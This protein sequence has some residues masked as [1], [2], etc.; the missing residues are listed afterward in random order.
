MKKS[1]IVLVAAS[2]FSAQSQGEVKVVEEQKFE[3]P[4]T[5]LTDC[6]LPEENPIILRTSN[7]WPEPH[8]SSKK[9]RKY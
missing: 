7:P 5:P 4:P 2:I 8:R 1:K 3:T 6:F 9:R